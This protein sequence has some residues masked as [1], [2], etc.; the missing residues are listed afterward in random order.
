[1]R[2]TSKKLP[3]MVL[4]VSL[5]LLVASCAYNDPGSPEVESLVLHINEFMAQNTSGIQDEAGSYEDWLEIY[6]PGPDDVEMGGLFLSDNL[7]ETTQWAFP[8]TVLEAGE[9]LLVWCDNDPGDGP[10]HATFK[11]SAGGEE[12]GLFHSIA[13]GN[14]V[15]DSHVYSAQTANVSEGRDSDG[16][17]T[18]VSFTEPT[19]GSSNIGNGPAPVVAVL[20]R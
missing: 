12:I 5:G 11:L 1:M 13:E 3:G 7:S 17:Q 18:W 14:E 8:D 19:P 10:L 15:I 20:Q 16:S 4:G 9:F 2:G 6:N